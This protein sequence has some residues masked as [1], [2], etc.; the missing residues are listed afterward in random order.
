MSLL[1]DTRDLIESQAAL[2][3]AVVVALDGK[4][5]MTVLDLCLPYFKRVEAFIWVYAFGMERTRQRQEFVK[6]RWG[7][8]LKEV[9]HYGATAHRH[10]GYYC[11][12]Q[13]VGDAPIKIG[14]AIEL[15]RKEYGIPLV[16]TGTRAYEHFSRRVMIQRGTWPGWHPIA[17]WRRSDVLSYMQHNNI[18]LPDGNGDM[19]D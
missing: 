10:D 18:P 1:A 2:H 5:S 4:D 6:A 14:P 3:D 7:V 11:F 17:Q 13:D 19:D 9:E 15:Q 16:A 12:A 8:D